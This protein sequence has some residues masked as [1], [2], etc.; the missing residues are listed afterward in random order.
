MSNNKNE[1]SQHLPSS[2]QQQQQ[3]PLVQQ[4]PGN[5]NTLML[6]NHSIRDDVRQVGVNARTTTTT[7]TTAG[8]AAAA[9]VATHSTNDGDH[10]IYDP[11]KSAAPSVEDYRD[12]ECLVEDEKHDTRRRKGTYLRRRCSS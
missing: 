10:H 2:H 1:R 4:Q 12:D 3:H 6:Y 8:A 7:K 9:A 11:S 5:Y